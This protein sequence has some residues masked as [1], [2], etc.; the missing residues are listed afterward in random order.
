MKKVLFILIIFSLL[1]LIGCKQTPT[2][3]TIK[4]VVCNEPYIRYADDCCLDQ[5]NNKICDNDEKE[6]KK[7][8]SSYQPVQA[9]TVESCTNNQY[10]DCIWSYMTKEEV[11]FKLQAKKAGSFVIKKISMPNVPCEKE[12]EVVDKE[13][14]LKFDDIVEIHI[15]CEFK[16]DSVESDLFISGFFYKWDDG[17]KTGVAGYEDSD[18]IITKSWISGMVR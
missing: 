1:F 2:G 11:Q 14:G 8:D 16:K 12:F 15:P 5:N 13:E 10:F 17:R 7:T 6:D 3:E 9:L 4:G 18:E